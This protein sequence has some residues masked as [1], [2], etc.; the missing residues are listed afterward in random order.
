LSA[1]WPEYEWRLARTGVAQPNRP[2]PR[3]DGGDPAGRTI[4]LQSEQGHGDAI[5]LV[6]YA[7]IIAAR[8]ARVLVS[9]RPPLRRLLRTAPGVEAIYEDASHAPSF[10]AWSPML[11]LPALL[12][13]TLAAIPAAGAY[14]RP[15]PALVQAWRQR[16]AGLQG[17][18][19]GVV[20]R[21]APDHLNDR[22]RSA[23]PEAFAGLLSIPGL[24]VVSLQQDA[25]P[26]ELAALGVQ[27][28]DAGPLL[29]DFAD[30]A[31]LIANLD[32]VVSVD[33]AVAHLA[34]ALGAPVWTLIAFAPDWRWLL[35]RG[36]AP[37][38]RRCACFRQSAPGHW[39]SAMGAARGALSRLA[40]A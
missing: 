32:L 24:A 14:L 2:A 31:A 7:S 4:L 26:D 12:G 1:G 22:H 28:L 16:L 38:I 30:T 19:V 17:L 27:A 15:D 6:R 40:G 18:K 8:G 20:W 13:T 39:A 35:G 36:T 21:G 34:G 23:G 3:W 25:R 11:S 10:E 29:G 37:G 5:Q 33:T 9:C